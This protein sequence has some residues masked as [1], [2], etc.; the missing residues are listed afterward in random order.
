MSAQAP[1]EL[2]RY[3][4]V[5]LA[6][7]AAAGLVGALVGAEALNVTASGS[8]APSPSEALSIFAANAQ[9]AALIL[10]GGSVGGAARHELGEGHARIA[11]L[12]TGTGDALVVAVVAF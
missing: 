3:T 12:L 4:L 6:L 5:V 10:A 9:V 11:R 2:A 1:R 8:G 7:A